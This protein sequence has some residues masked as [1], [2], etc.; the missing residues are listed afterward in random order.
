[1]FFTIRMFT[2]DKGL[3][4][5]AIGHFSIDFI[6][7]KRS[8]FIF[9]VLHIFRSEFLF[10]TGK[11]KGKSQQHGSCESFAY[12]TRIICHEVGKLNSKRLRYRIAIEI[13]GSSCSYLFCNF[14]NVLGWEG[15]DC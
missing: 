8:V 15:N 6:K 13:S 12:F 7:D 2:N 3:L 9:A 5:V 10:G 4:V 14:Q 1:M 11:N